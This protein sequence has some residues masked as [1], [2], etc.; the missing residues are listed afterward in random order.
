V[1]RRL[2]SFLKPDHFYAKRSVCKKQTSGVSVGDESPRRLFFRQF[3][4]PQKEMA[5]PLQ[6]FVETFKKE[7]RLF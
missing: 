1:L 7:K 2:R 5:S 6:T 3:L 4:F